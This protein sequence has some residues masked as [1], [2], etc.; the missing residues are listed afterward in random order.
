VLPISFL[1]YVLFLLHLRLL[2][3]HHGYNLGCHLLPLENNTEI[4]H[5]RNERFMQRNIFF[6]ESFIL[7]LFLS[8]L[9][10]RRLPNLYHFH[11]IQLHH[12]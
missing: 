11:L 8:Y 12:Q 1:S 6:Q 2:Q 7:L 5:N 10:P 9:L 4:R 3:T